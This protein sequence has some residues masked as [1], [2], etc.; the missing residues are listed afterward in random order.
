MEHLKSAL[1]TV[2]KIAEK[3]D[4]ALADGKISIA[5]G[6][7]I[8]FSA[9]GLIKVVKNINKI[10]DDFDGLTNQS[11]A[12]LIT[13]FKNEF[14]IRNDNVEDI[15]EMIFAALVNLGEVFDALKK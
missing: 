14:D 9:I 10:V 1:T 15:V 8:A 7:G 13:W 5:E 2:I 3:A 4:D 12:E 6:I 11:R